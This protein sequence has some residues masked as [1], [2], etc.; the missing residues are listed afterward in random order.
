VLLGIV[1]IVKPQLS[2]I[3]IWALTRREYRL[4]L[5]FLVVVGS[6][7]LAS[8]AVYGL[9]VHLEYVQLLEFLSKRGE[10]FYD[11]QAINGLLNRLV[12][13]GNNLEWDGTHT[14]I[15]YIPWIHDVT[16]ATSVAIVVPTLI[17]RGRPGHG[18]ASW[19]DFGI[20][21]VSYTLASPI[22]Y[23]PH[24][25]FILPLY[26]MILLAV[27]RQPSTPQWMWWALAISFT[28]CA[29]LLSPTRSLAH[30]YL[31]IL[32]SYTLFGIIILLVLLYKLRSKAAS[33]AILALPSHALGR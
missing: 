2:L 21:L 5:G 11:N 25:G 15:P 9:P 10:S 33:E 32:Q 13:N 12:F 3:L 28:L 1:C 24:F 14:R 7:G 29:N 19:I 18:M 26:F 30:T 31:N 23:T 16:I 8:L 17:Y 6:I 22:A 20:A 27:C 4:A